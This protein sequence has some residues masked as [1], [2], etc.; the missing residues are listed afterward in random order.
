MCKF[1]LYCQLYINTTAADSDYRVMMD[2]PL[3]LSTTYPNH[4]ITIYI[5]ND[6]EVESTETLTLEL[7]F[8]GG[9]LPRVKLNPST[10]TITIFDDDDRG[11][12]M[13]MYST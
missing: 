12:C 5:V 2:T 11:K 9:P 6:E 4:T 7:S 8:P 3:I 10:A 13:Y 1:T